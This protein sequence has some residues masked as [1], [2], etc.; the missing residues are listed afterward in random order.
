MSP[1]LT[2]ARPS[3]RRVAGTVFWSFFGVRKR[4]DHDRESI[5]L[6]PPQ[7]IAGALVGVA[8]FITTILTLVHFITR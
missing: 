8:L 6:T 4:S 2:Q 3:L 5:Q 7:V 1:P